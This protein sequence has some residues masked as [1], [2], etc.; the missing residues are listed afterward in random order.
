M[1]EYLSSRIKEQLDELTFNFPVVFALTEDTDFTANNYDHQIIFYMLDRRFTKE[2]T[3]INSTEVIFRFLVESKTYPKDNRNFPQVLKIVESVNQAL[4][5]L[6]LGF[7]YHFNIND[8]ATS[9]ND[10]G[11]YQHRIDFSLF[12]TVTSDCFDELLKKANYK[13]VNLVVSTF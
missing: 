8:S 1:I 6:N 3:G 11:V 12:F 5:K 2:L 9:L 7:S 10:D 13:Q 4:S